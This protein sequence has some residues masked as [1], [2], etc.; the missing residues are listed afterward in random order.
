[1]L[2]RGGAVELARPAR[3]K[4]ILWT[5]GAALEPAYYVE[6]FAG[7][8]GHPDSE[9]HRW[10]VSG[11]DGRVLDER[12][13]TASDFQYR[14][15][16][17]TTGDKRPADGP[18]EDF[19]PHPTGTPDGSSPAF[20]APSLVS[21][22]GFNSAPGGGHD[23]WLPADA[24]VATGNNVEA[25]ADIAAPDGFTEGS[26]IRPAV[27]S[28]GV[29]DR[30]Y[31]L[32]A[33]PL[34]T[35]DQSMSGVMQAFYVTNFLHDWYYDSG[36][37]EAAGNAQA[38]N[39]GRGGEEGDV[40]H[41]EG[42]DN[43]NGGSR[44]NANMSTPADGDSP[45][46][47]MFVWSGNDDASLTLNPG[48]SVPVGT[49]AFGPG[50]FDLAATAIVEGDDG[51]GTTTD[52]CEALTNNVAGQIV[53]VDRGSCTFATKARNA[54]AAGAVAVIIA[55]NTGTTPNSL[56]GD[57]GGPVNIPAM[58]VSMPQGAALR[59]ALGNGAVTGAMHRVQG[60]ERDGDLDSAVVAHEWGH[61]LHHRLADCGATQCGGMSEG[62]GDFN[63]LH[64]ML[65]EGDDVDGA[66]AAAAYAAASFGDQFF[67]IRRVAY[68]VDPAKD[69]LSFRHIADG[70]PLPTTAPIAGT[71]GGN[72]EVH[73]VG[74]I[75]ATMMWEAY[76]SLVRP[77]T[78][79]GATRTFDQARRAMS[80]YVVAGLEL[81]PVDATFT[82][83]R[84]AIL[85]AAAAADPADL[86]AMAQAFAR[87]GA[88][89]CA[90]SP[91]R[92]S[93]DLTGVVEDDQ[94]RPRVDLGVAA[95]VAGTNDCDGD[96]I[97]DA[98][99][100]AALT[101][102]VRNG[103]AATATATTVTVSS[104]ATEVDFPDGASADIATLAPYEETTLTFPVHLADGA[105]PG[106][107]VAFEVA[108]DNSDSCVTTTTT[109]TSTLAEVD[110]VLAAS[111]SD[112]VEATASAWTPGGED[113]AGQVWNRVDVEAGNHAWVGVDFGGPT[114]TMLES[115]DLEVSAT[116]AFT[117]TAATKWSFEAD[118]TFWD[119][120]VIEVSTDGGSTWADISTYVDPGYGGVITNQSGNPLADRNAFVAQNAS[121]P[122]TDTLSLDL[123]TQ[124]AGQT[125]RVRFRI[126][127]DAAVGAF[128]WQLD[129]LAFGGID[130]T[131]FSAV[132]DDGTT[133]ADVPTPDAGT[134]GG[135]A[136]D[137][138]AEG[139]DGGC[140]STGGAGAGPTLLLL[141]AVLLGWPRRRKAA[142]R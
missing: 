131:P 52:G 96:G 127:T 132:V 58:S 90:V 122:D 6:A 39:F 54:E 86:T 21:M 57:Q 109:V 1:H 83:A 24:T 71:G 93:Q 72:S 80:D 3:V 75:W 74:E 139:D 63:A 31:D 2:A 16:A 59:T 84:D 25:Y 68:S 128:G 70:E 50:S 119:G 35:T 18:T 136:G 69:A 46:M 53:L 120:G 48:G 142:R 20:V 41:V 42:Q 43:V 51:T 27:T 81:T 104:T 37:D 116:E 94:V 23:P 111:A 100:T 10:I 113:E 135:D 129:D 28:P 47:Q 66:Y 79:A 4:R 7:P 106:T 19:T 133:C 60:V 141:G 124:L 137:P 29:F 22:D 123:G 8:A 49:A 112:D 44:N 40:M 5:R 138:G 95:V 126:G 82:E 97:F 88:G 55:N 134:G 32:N 130:N 121:W 99:E 14:V 125:V 92:D 73:N 98:G 38:S 76:I 78:E 140:C 101:V 65:R 12:D 36:F 26:D 33:G 56:G 110:E 17:D 67:G 61:Y 108:A 103:G 9:A 89:T 102:T 11:K 15:W 34:A 118:T 64:M 87:R 105:A 114:D 45:R 13:L 91:A 30:T 77:T 107:V 62:W 117:I 85:A 115:P